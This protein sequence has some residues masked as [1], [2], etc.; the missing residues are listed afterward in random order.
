[1]G[2]STDARGDT[3]ILMISPVSAANTAAATSIWFPTAAY[4]GDIEVTA[5]V[6][7]LTG[8]IT[9]KLR[10]ATSDVGAGAADIAGATFTAVSAADKVQTV[11]VPASSARFIQYV[12]TVVTGPA[13]VAVTMRAHPGYV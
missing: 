8:T 2:I 10:S 13:I 3:D 4:K 5:A 1:M 7:A 12:G 11:V 9:G 6:G